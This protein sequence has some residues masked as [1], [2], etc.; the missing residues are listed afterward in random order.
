[1]V[2]SPGARPFNG[3]K[4]RKSNVILIH[5]GTEKLLLSVAGHEL[6]HHLRLT[7]PALYDELKAALWPLMQNTAQF[8]V[9]LERRGQAKADM[10]EELIADFVGDNL[11]RPG[12]WATLKQREPD[13]F[14]RVARIV[15][16]WLDK[17]LARLKSVP[18][19][20]SDPYFTDLEQARH[21]VASAL[22]DAAR[23]TQFAARGVP[24]RET[25]T[26]GEA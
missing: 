9:R 14:T 7:H 12:F 16:A 13:L 6:L 18:G 11:A 19:F 17:L 4:D 5:A 3:F 10:A 24:G 25:I 2:D 8:R 22:V 21:V 1:M 20:A 23:E 15:R 26:A